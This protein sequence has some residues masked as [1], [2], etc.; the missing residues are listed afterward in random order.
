MRMSRTLEPLRTEVDEAR[1]I[2]MEGES[3]ACETLAQNRQHAFGVDNVVERHQRVIG[4]ADKGAL[5]SETR[6][7]HGL[8]PLVQHMVQ[9]DVREAG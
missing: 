8:E 7:H 9:K 6:P 1:L 5:S 2:G 3:I 4:V